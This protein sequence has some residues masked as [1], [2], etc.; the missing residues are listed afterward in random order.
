MILRSLHLM[1][2][3]QCTLECAHCFAW[4]SP[5]QRGTM[6]SDD[7]DRILDQ[8]QE[9]GTIDWIYFEGGEAFLYYATLLHGVRRAAAMNFAVG[10]VTNSYWAT[11]ER[12]ALA[13]LRP[14]A[15]LVQDLSASEDEYHIIDELSGHVANARKAATMLGIPLGT[16]SISQPEDANAAAAVGKLPE[17]QSAIMY[18]GRAAETLTPRAMLFPWQQFDCCPYENLHDPGRIHVDPLGHL[19][20]CQGISLGNLFEVPLAE[21]WERYDPPQHPIAGP[22]L[23]GGPAGL[24]HHHELEIDGDYADACHLCDT[25]RRML[26]SRYPEILTPDQMYGVLDGN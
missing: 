15:G 21:I 11:S 13:W 7:V 12:D 26:R 17:G 3:Y 1:L 5:W 18:R 23:E 25:V 19:H 14:F 22:L 6:T 10:I 24:A 8:A 20:L 4:G 2:T 9:L 16:I